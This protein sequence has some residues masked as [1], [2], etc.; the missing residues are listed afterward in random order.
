ML[1][2]EW[3]TRKKAAEDPGRPGRAEHARL[4]L[5]HV[6]SQQR[7]DQ[8]GG[9]GGGRSHR[10]DVLG[11]LNSRFDRL[12]L[13]QQLADHDPGAGRDDQHGRRR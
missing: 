7:V 12:G 8:E 10:E 13:E 5:A 6:T 2:S 3:L 9:G 4:E 11:T 1:T